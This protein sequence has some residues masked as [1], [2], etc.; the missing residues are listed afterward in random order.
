LA[1]VA[2]TEHNAKV[3]QLVQES[4]DNENK[5][6]SRSASAFNEFFLVAIPVAAAVYVGFL[7]Y[8]RRR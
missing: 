1:R 7:V 2:L 4:V 3:K 6:I 8:T 5:K